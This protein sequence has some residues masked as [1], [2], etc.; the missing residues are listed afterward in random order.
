MRQLYDALEWEDEGIRD[1]AKEIMSNFEK[2][3]P[4]GMDEGEGAGGDGEDGEEEEE[5]EW[6]SDGANDD[7]M[8]D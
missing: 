3:L 2:E 1:H 7:E 6:E 4:E 8:K 5:G